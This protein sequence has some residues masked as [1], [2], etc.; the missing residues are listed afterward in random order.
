MMPCDTVKDV[1]PNVNA[2]ARCGMAEEQTERAIRALQAAGSFPCFDLPC[3]PGS[4]VTADGDAELCNFGELRGDGTP[5][6]VGQMYASVKCLDAH[7]ETEP[8]AVNEP[9]T[10]AVADTGADEFEFAPK[11]SPHERFALA[12][13]EV[14]VALAGEDVDFKEVARQLAAAIVSRLNG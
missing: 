9:E 5:Y 14:C 4:F 11:P 7:G 3:G 2:R 8:E 12:L 10:E 13:G 6:S 1:Q